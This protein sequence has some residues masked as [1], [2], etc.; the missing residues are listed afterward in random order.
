MT[1][2]I[3]VNEKGEKAVDLILAKRK[4]V[5]RRR[6]P[7][8]VGKVFAVQPGRGKK[9]VAYA[10]VV[11]C[12]G[13][14]SWIYRKS[15]ADLEKEAKRE[16]FVTWAGLM[17]WFATHNIKNVDSLFRI[18]FKIL[19]PT[20]GKCGVCGKQVAADALVWIARGKISH[21]ECGHE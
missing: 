12:F 4:T 17:N 11:S 13:H 8:P 15:Q 14:A 19:E 6:E 18:E 10:K 3:S 20:K 1:I 21:V 9:A 7:M 2:F 16:G 5:T